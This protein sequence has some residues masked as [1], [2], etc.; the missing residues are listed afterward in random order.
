MRAKINVNKDSMEVVN[1]FENIL[2]SEDT[3]VIHISG[4]RDKTSKI[5]KTN[6][7]LTKIFGYNKTE[8]IGHSINILMPSLFAKRHNEFLGK[9]FET[10]HMTVFNVQRNFFGLHRNGLCF[11]IITLIKQM[12]SLLDGIQYVGMI[13][14]QSNECDYILTDFYVW[15]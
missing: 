15:K 1:K 5:L 8:V 2:F 14:Q 11:T 3:V 9:F 12:P 7:N 4:A 6:Q 10:G 13:R